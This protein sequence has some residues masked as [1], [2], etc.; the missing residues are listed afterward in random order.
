MM[1][2]SLVRHGHSVGN[3]HN[4]LSGW[5]DVPLT[6]QGKEEL[7]G[8]KSSRNYLTTDAY[9]SSDLSRAIET[10]KILF[11]Y[12]N[13]ETRASFREINFGKYENMSPRQINFKDFFTKW[14]S[15]KEIEG[16]ENYYQFTK[17]I[18][19]SFRELNEEVI[20]KKLDSYTLVSHS[21][22]IR[23]IL[24]CLENKGPKDFFDY[25]VPNGL[26]YNIILEYNGHDY[27]LIKIDSI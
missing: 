23:A 20:S 2:I 4:T 26:G 13:I 1:K 19:K 12:E 11:P 15:G 18:S 6:K 17:R 16:G 24:G 8:Y 7:L 22:V 27:T 21:G 5:T 25:H 10:A 3:L 9:Y 14:F